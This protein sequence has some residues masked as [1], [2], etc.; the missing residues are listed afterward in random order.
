MEGGCANDILIYF[1]WFLSLQ[2]RSLCYK[3]FNCYLNLLNA[4]PCKKQDWNFFEHTLD[5]KISERTLDAKVDFWT[6]SWCKNSEH[7]LDPKISEHT[8]DSK[9][10]KLKIWCRFSIKIYLICY[11]FKISTSKFTYYSKSS[12]IGTHRIQTLSLQIIISKYFPDSIRKV[13]ENKLKR[14]SHK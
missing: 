9:N 11:Q 4:N 1:L 8:L 2:T 14:V 3:L 12:S 7:T 5:T 13:F 10:W 6:H